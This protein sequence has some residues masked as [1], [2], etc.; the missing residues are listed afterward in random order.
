[1]GSGMR[2]PL[3][4]HYTRVTGYAFEAGLHC[5]ECATTRFGADD[6]GWVPA[7]ATDR[8]GNDVFAI[9]SGEEREQD[10]ETCST[11]GEVFCLRCGVILSDYAS[12]P[13]P[14]ALLELWS[15]LGRS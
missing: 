4:I 6:H 8:E 12:D 13:H 14:C 3:G 15:S 10:I 5:I 1:M 7:T 9:F 11:C 2:S